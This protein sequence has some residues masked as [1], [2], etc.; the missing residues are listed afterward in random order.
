[1]DTHVALGFQARPPGRA[2]HA[3]P[4]G[5]GPLPDVVYPPSFRSWV[6]ISLNLGPE[7]GRQ[8]SI[9]VSGALPGRASDLRA[10]ANPMSL[11]A[12]DVH[13]AAAAQRHFR[14]ARYLCA[15]STPDVT[16]GLSGVH[17]AAA[18]VTSGLP[19]MCAGST[20][21]SLPA[22]LMCAW[23]HTSLP[24]PLW[25]YVRPENEPHGFLLTRKENMMCGGVSGSVTQRLTRFWRFVGA[26]LEVTQSCVNRLHMVP[27]CYGCPP[28]SALLRHQS[29]W[30]PARRQV[31]A[32]V[33]QTRIGR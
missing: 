3:G 6:P 32:K 13:A 29:S 28:H 33:L 7:Q 18:N 11:P 10:E 25:R 20:P 15:G 31:T 8:L 19:D 21:M 23:K 1:M 5:P 14:P 9:C 27:S 30:L 16:S 24:A 26:Y 17:A 12:C 4:P 2:G 22:C